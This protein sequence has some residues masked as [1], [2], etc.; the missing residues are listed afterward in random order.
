MLIIIRFRILPVWLSERNILLGISPGLLRLGL[1]GPSEEI[2]ISLSR[3]YL[4]TSLLEVIRRSRVS[5]SRIFLVMRIPIILVIM[6]SPRIIIF[7]L[8]VGYRFRNLN[9]FCSNPGIIPIRYFRMI[10]IPP[11]HP[12]YRVVKTIPKEVFILLH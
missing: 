8:L 12:L 7:P 2:I 4:G 1:A 9:G 6:V 10:S 5:I 3:W 11:K